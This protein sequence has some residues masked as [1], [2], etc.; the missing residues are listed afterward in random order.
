MKTR[1]LLYV[2]LSMFF[3]VQ[4]Q[5]Q[6]QLKKNNSKKNEVFSFKKGKLLYKDNFDENLKN[7]VPEMP[8]SPA[9]VVVIKDKK[10]V[11]DVNGGAT[12][13]LNKKLSGNIII[14]YK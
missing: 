13:W 4:G 9:S 2:L 10:L 14:T 7:W 11:I 1:V 3:I 8:K 12:V 5:E 6:L